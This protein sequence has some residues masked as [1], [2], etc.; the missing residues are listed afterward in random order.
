MAGVSYGGQTTSFVY[1]PA[2]ERVKVVV[3]SATTVYVGDSYEKNLSTGVVTTYYT[4]GGRRVGLRQGASTYWLH[5]DQTNHIDPSG[6]C[7]P[8]ENCPGDSAADCFNSVYY[9]DWRNAAQHGLGISCRNVGCWSECPMQRSQGP[10]D[11]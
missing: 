1:G 9:R 11:A 7:I 6:H 8:G 2:G 10:G 3:G 4:F 5:A